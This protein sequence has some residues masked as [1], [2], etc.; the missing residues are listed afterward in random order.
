MSF[1]RNISVLF[2][3]LLL[4]HPAQALMFDFYGHVEYM[5]AESWGQFQLKSIGNKHQLQVAGQSVESRI[6]N[7]QLQKIKLMAF[8]YNLD[9]IGTILLVQKIVS[10]VS[11]DQNKQRLIEYVLLNKLGYDVICSYSSRDIFVYGVLSENP[12]QSIYIHFKSK[13]YTRL[14]FQELDKQGLCS[15]LPTTEHSD[16]RHFQLRKG[17]LPRVNAFTRGKNYTFV[18]NRKVYSIQ[19]KT[20]SSMRMYLKD[21]PRYKLGPTYV[22][23]PISEELRQSLIL[24]LQYFMKDMK[25]TREKSTFLLRFVQQAFKYKNDQEQYGMERYNF[26]EETLNTVYNDCEDKT[27]LLSYLYKN[28]L[29]IESVMLHFKNDKH[30]CLGAR[31]PGYASNGTFKYKGKTYVVCEPTG[32]NYRVGQTAIDLT[33]ITEVIPLM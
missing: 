19:A 32:K 28:L 22:D 13:R 31:I 25:T 14:A 23:M 27:M 26:P 15:I 17:S 20:N 3:M 9:D 4:K 7:D 12:A 1:I 33:R 8:R 10:R 11:S 29:G 30:V 24:K 5:D 2:L 18:H 6:N 16:K 21:L